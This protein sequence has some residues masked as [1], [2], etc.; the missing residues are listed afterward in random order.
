MQALAL[1]DGRVEGRQ[2]VDPLP[3]GIEGGIERLG[4]RPVLQRS[5]RFELDAHQLPAASPGLYQ[6]PHGRLARRVEIAGRIDAHDALRS[7]RTVELIVEDLSFRR[8]LRR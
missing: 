1:M 7:Q 8:G 5:G 3:G 2:D 6:S 4:P